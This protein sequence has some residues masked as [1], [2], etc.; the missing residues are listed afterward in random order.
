M[1]EGVFPEFPLAGVVHCQQAHAKGEPAF[2]LESGG[3]GTH[4]HLASRSV[5]GDRKSTRLNSSHGYNSYAGF[6]LEKKQKM[7][8]SG[9]GTDILLPTPLA[10]QRTLQP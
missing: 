3:R 10:L 9:L 2:A 5:G 8:A 1:L 4:E 7:T 6:F